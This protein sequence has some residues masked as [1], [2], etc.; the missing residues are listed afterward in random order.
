MASHLKSHHQNDQV[1]VD[2]DEVAVPTTIYVAAED[3]IQTSALSG[4]QPPS[5]AASVTACDVEDKNQAANISVFVRSVDTDQTPIHVAPKQKT[6]NSTLQRTIV[7]IVKLY[8]HIQGLYKILLY[9]GW[10]WELVALAVS[11][12]SMAAN[13]GVLCKVDGTA[14]LDWQFPIQPNSLVSVFM[15]VSRSALLVPIAECISQTKWFNFGQAPGKLMALQDL[16]DASRGPWGSAQ[17][18][19][20]PRKIGWAAW[21]GAVL[22]VISLALDPFTQQI[23]AFPT[24]LVPSAEGTAQVASTQSAN[25][26]TTAVSQA[27]V[28]SSIYN[29]NSDSPINWTCTSANCQW[30]RPVTSL[31]ICSTCRNITSQFP[32]ACQTNPGPVLPQGVDLSTTT[33]TY[34]VNKNVT[35]PIYIQT[36][37]LPAANGRPAEH[38]SQYT[39]VKMTSITVRQLLG[40]LIDPKIGGNGWIS[41][42]LSWTTSFNDTQNPMP[43]ITIQNL[44][45][46]LFACGLY[47]CAQ[48]YDTLAVTNG[49][50]QDKTPSAT[51]PLRNQPMSSSG[52]SF[53]EIY[54]LPV[55]EQENFPG[56]ATFTVAQQALFNMQGALFGVLNLTQHGGNERFSFFPEPNAGLDGL[57][58]SA[59]K[60]VS[61]AFNRI[62]AS[63]TEL[64]R[65]SPGSRPAPGKALVDETYVQ[66]RW[67]WMALPLGVLALAGVLLLVTILQNRR[68]RTRLWKSS[69]LALL[70]HPLQGCEEQDVVDVESLEQMERFASRVD[71]KLEQRSGGEGN[72]FV[73][74]GECS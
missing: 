73:R 21:L 55:P 43:P 57:S 72:V 16:D 69:A 25:K 20:S 5:L 17:L 61:G 56:N 50:L 35:F 52:G 39:H 74:V 45:P 3:S 65:D 29:Q 10:L 18:L 44:Y 9:R 37:H 22:T 41:T 4:Q 59:Y 1:I 30:D 67:G 53:S 42:V 8:L 32:P 14:L 24:R 11:V 27:A 51:Y 60:N 63:L 7:G 19:F 71:V 49:T 23:M 64:I 31:S 40:D 28:L 34:K 62:A 54:A 12:L 26:L 33:C 13:L 38:A 6:A 15:T 36:L 58:S 2:G 66:V 48:V 68:Q 46:D 70:M 47:F